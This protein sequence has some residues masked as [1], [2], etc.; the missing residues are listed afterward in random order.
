MYGPWWLVVGCGAG[1]ERLQ[2]KEA[3]NP[4]LLAAVLVAGPSHSLR[5][6]L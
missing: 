4:C 6:T 5:A 3:L 2:G 1:G